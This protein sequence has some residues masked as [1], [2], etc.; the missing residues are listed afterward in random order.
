MKLDKAT[1]L[2]LLLA[3]GGIS[4]GLLLEG[5][6]LF[7]V[8]QPTAALIV[9]GGT[10]GAT[11]VSQPF[12]DILGAGRQFV[13][14]FKESES[15]IDETVELIVKLAYEAR[16]SGIISLE[17]K[18]AEIPDRFM[19]KALM[20]AV[21]GTEP[22]DLRE[23][24]EMEISQYVARRE[25]EARV[26]ESAGG[27]SPTIGIIG[28]VLGLIQVMKHLDN[29]DEVGK[30]IAVAFV[31]TIYGVGIANLVLLPA[32][33]KI[34]GRAQ[35]AAMMRELML[36]G[37]ISLTEGLNP[38]LIRSKLEGYQDEKEEPEGDQTSQSP[39]APPKEM[40]AAAQK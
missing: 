36:E 23:I 4:A 3:I 14:I 35:E 29:I 6:S 26:F 12:K 33:K 39:S 21:D 16:R 1:I 13:G 27:Y 19:R 37:V 7:E 40:H 20:L 9:L 32:S 8:L 11:M 2:G 5:G 30:G 10:I 28:A 17:K 18:L 24:M 31:A 15:D 38:R 25:A 34:I 22:K